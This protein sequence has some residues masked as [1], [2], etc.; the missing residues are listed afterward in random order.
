MSRGHVNPGVTVRAA[1]VLATPIAARSEGPKNSL[2]TV[3]TTMDPTCAAMLAGKQLKPG[4]YE[5]NADEIALTLERNVQV[6]AE[7]SVPWEGRT[8]HRTPR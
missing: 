4:T 1:M 7:V 6:L 3:R 5:V 2:S 8:S